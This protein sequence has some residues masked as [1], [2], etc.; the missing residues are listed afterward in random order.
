MPTT[1]SLGKLLSIS[2]LQILPSVKLVV[3][4]RGSNYYLWLLP[5][6]LFPFTNFID[7]KEKE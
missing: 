7:T 3:V 2:K 1:V 4:G 6:R 5:V